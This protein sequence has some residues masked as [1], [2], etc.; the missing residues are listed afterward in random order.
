MSGYLDYPGSP[1]VH[2]EFPGDTREYDRMRTAVQLN[3]LQLME[4]VY[5][6]HDGEPVCPGLL[7]RIA[8]DIVDAYS[9]NLVRPEGVDLVAAVRCFV[10]TILYDIMPDAD[11]LQEYLDFNHREEL[12]KLLGEF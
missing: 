4:Q 9:R 7:H 10:A 2:A 11:W 3:R 1:G 5:N 12:G 8:D 6:S